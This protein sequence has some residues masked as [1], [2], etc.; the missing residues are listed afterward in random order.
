MRYVDS[1]VDKGLEGWSP[2]SSQQLLLEMRLEMGSKRSFQFLFPILLYAGL[3]QY[4]LCNTIMG[5][6]K[7]WLWECRGGG[8]WWSQSG[9][10]QD[11]LG[12]GQDPG[13]SA[14]LLCALGPAAAPLWAEAKY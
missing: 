6:F 1:V 11:S 8:A 4:G 3:F 9:T 5:E 13:L 7:N 2:F 12:K 10:A 14:D